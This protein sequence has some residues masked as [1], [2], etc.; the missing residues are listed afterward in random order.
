MFYLLPKNLLKGGPN[1][2]EKDLRRSDG[3]FGSDYSGFEDGV[4]SHQSHL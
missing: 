4:Q 3:G 1:V 2:R